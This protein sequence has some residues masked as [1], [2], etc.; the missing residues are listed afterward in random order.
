MQNCNSVNNNV[1]A[2]KST[3]TPVKSNVQES[4]CDISSIQI[5]IPD[6]VKKLDVNS[7]GLQVEPEDDIPPVNN[8]DVVP[9]YDSENNALKQ[10]VSPLDSKNR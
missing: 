4:V 9:K 7:N 5:N 8:I 6:D 2:I 1:N 3:S 10:Y